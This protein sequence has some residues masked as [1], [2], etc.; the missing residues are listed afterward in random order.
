M[1]DETE[2]RCRRYGEVKPI[3]RFKLSNGY[4]AHV[5]RHCAYLIYRKRAIPLYDEAPPPLPAN[6]IDAVIA[7]YRAEM[8]R[9][10]KADKR[11]RHRKAEK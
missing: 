10:G 2:K 11:Y 5:C 9:F 3:D 4:R 1:S 8:G 7:R 6:N